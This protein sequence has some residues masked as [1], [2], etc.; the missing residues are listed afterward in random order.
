MLLRNDMPVGI[1][2]GIAKNGGHA[3]LKPLRDEVLEPLRLVM[4]LIPGILQNIVKKQLEQ[5]VMS[6]QFPSSAFARRGQPNA[7][8]LFVMH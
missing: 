2:L 8:V 7:V 1:H 3:V 5:A 6:Q 4:N